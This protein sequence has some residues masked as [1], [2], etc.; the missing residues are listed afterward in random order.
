MVDN[1]MTAMNDDLG[2]D[3]N[4]Q[5][6]RFVKELARIAKEHSVIILLIAHPKKIGKEQSFDNDDVSGSSN[7][8]NLCDIV[9][10]YA[11][12][13]DMRDTNERLLCITKNRL[14]GRTNYEGVPLWFEETTKRISAIEGLF[15]WSYGWEKPEE[16]FENPEDLD[17]IP[18]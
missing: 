5:Q 1:L 6:T 4:R 9:M 2:A 8:T 15:D 12:P 11:R 18:F 3:L 16:A 10:R 7:I 14:T 17:E 13:K